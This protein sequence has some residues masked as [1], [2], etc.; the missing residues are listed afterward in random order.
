MRSHHLDYSRIRRDRQRQETERQQ[1]RA[2]S[3][4]SDLQQLREKL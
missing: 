4:E 3:A 2:E 1:E